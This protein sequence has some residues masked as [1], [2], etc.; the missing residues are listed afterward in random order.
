MPI[1][2]VNG[3]ELE[4]PDD[5]GQDAIRDVLR[6]KFPA[7]EAAPTDYISRVKGDFKQS[8]QKIA[9][10][11]NADKNPAIAGTQILAEGINAATAPIGEGLVSGFKAVSPYIPQ[12]AKDS[13]AQ[14]VGGVFGA[15]ESLP[16]K[17]S[18]A[19]NKTR[20]GQ[21]LGNYLMDSPA[22]QN[23]MQEVSDTAKAVGTIATAAPIGRGLIKA[24]N[25]IAPTAIKVAD[26]MTGGLV[27]DV[28]SGMSNK[29][30]AAFESRKLQAVQDV[31][32][33]KQTPKEI[34]DTALKRTNSGGFRNKQIYAPDAS[35]A[36][37]IKI[38]REA[39]VNPKALLADNIQKLNTVRI[40]KAKALGSQLDAAPT[41]ITQASFD[42]YGQTLAD[43]IISNKF[44]KPHGDTVTALLETAQEVINANPKNAAGLWQARKAFDQAIEAFKPNVFNPTAA[45]TAFN[46]TAKNIR[47]GMNQLIIDSSPNADVAKFLKE[48][49]NLSQAIENMAGKLPAQSPVSGTLK[50]DT[51]LARFLATKTGKVA[52]AGAIAGGL[53]VAGNGVINSIGAK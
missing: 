44:L 50:G 45:D 48:Y 52:K 53:G 25:Q 36:E 49:S 12:S 28:N 46:Y 1:V 13:A 40:E 41:P 17:A 38:A 16:I 3:Q 37:M 7:Q 47:N 23:A 10:I 43:N 6:A 20:A 32:L 15:I 42:K 19:V 27:S 34:A 8:G 11:W 18:Q 14:S 24:T 30:R 39:G 4:F 33:P 26:K 31:V 22:A 51:R 35:E 2:E 5:M 21:A 9:D 29:A